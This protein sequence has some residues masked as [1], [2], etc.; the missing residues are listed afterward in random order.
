MPRWDTRPGSNCR[1]ILRLRYPSRVTPGVKTDATVV[2][3]ARLGA[4]SQGC[5]EPFSG[6]AARS[7]MREWLM[8]S[9]LPR[10]GRYP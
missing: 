2:Q 3:P 8:T 10:C 9:S 7:R 4:W 5:D 1:S 6:D